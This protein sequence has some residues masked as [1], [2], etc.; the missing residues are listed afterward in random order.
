[1]VLTEVPCGVAVCPSPTASPLPILATAIPVEVVPWYAGHYYWWSDEAPLT[2][3]L[4]KQKGFIEA[5]DSVLQIFA[6]VEQRVLDEQNFLLRSTTL[7]RRPRKLAICNLEDIP[8][9]A[10]ARDQFKVRGYDLNDTTNC[11]TDFRP[12][13]KEDI[14]IH[15]AVHTTQQFVKNN[16]KLIANASSG[17][18]DNDKLN[19]SE[20]DTVFD[21]AYNT[22]TEECRVNVLG[23]Y[24][25]RKN[26]FVT[27][28]ITN[29]PQ[30]EHLAAQKRHFMVESVGFNGTFDNEIMMR[31]RTESGTTPEIAT[32]SMM[33]TFRDV[34]A[35]AVIKAIPLEENLA[36]LYAL[37]TAQFYSKQVI[38]ATSP[39]SIA[40]LILPLGL[41]FVPIALFADVSTKWMLM[42]AFLSD[43]LTVIPLSIKG[44]ELI[45]IGT[46]KHFG[47]SVR[48]LSGVSGMKEEKVMCE[49]Y[50]AECTSTRSV[51]PTGIAFLVISLVVLV[52]GL[53]AEVKARRYMMKARRH[54]FAEM[55][56][57]SWRSSMSSSREARGRSNKWN[58]RRSKQVARRSENELR[59]TSMDTYDEALNNDNERHLS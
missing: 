26:W 8:W 23:G 38:D 25:V 43:I 53:V 42:Y 54:L 22:G 37:E 27:L 13:E 7:T 39:S 2:K 10:S 17:G 41:N 5:A 33:V 15:Y 44:V 59:R 46:T 1:M 40:I 45:L 51:L 58:G 32:T 31:V 55:L 6:D 19:F 11:V 50:V 28:S 36:V 49:M 47:T 52:I 57:S 14:E 48:M 34:A 24:R 18:I 4:S 56:R 16:A 20:P 3:T 9:R 12:N 21:W 35:P 29:R 30:E